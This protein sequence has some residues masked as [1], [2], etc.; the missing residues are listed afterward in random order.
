[1]ERGTDLRQSRTF[2]KSYPLE[3]HG[4]YKYES[5][6]D[7][8]GKI[9]TCAGVG[10]RGCCPRR[11]R[12]LAGHFE[13]TGLGCAHVSSCDLLNPQGLCPSVGTD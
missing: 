11:L 7:A 10:L 4:K 1:M 3:C 9:L 2:I 5:E 6:K 12:Y 13:P 8:H